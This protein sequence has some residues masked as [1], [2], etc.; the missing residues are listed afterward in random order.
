MTVTATLEVHDGA[1]WVEIPVRSWEMQETGRNP[2][3][4]LRC[5]IVSAALNST[6]LSLL[7]LYRRM[8]WTHEVDGVDFSFTGRIMADPR[9]LVGPELDIITLTCYDETHDAARYRFVD[10]WPKLDVDTWSEIIEDAWTRYGPKG[11]T[12]TGVESNTA[13]PDYISNPLNTLFDFM[14]DI[15]QRT[16]WRWKVVDGD[17]KFWDPT[18]NVGAQTITATD[19]RPG[20]MVDEG[21]PEVANIVFIP[22]E[23]RVQD[24]EDSQTT[25]TGRKQYFLQYSPLEIP[26]VTV[27]GTPVSE[28]DMAADGTPDADTADLVYNLENRFLRFAVAPTGGVD[29]VATYDAVLPVTVER[30]HPVS[31]GLYGEIQHTIRRSPRPSR[32][33]AAEIAD[34]YLAVHAL[35]VTAMKAEMLDKT[36]QCGWYYQ[37]TLEHIDQLMPCVAVSRAG[38]SDGR[39]VV[40]ASWQQAPVSD[41]EMIFDLFRRLER[42][43]A[44][45]TSKDER[46]ERDLNIEDTWHWSD[47]VEFAWS[48]CEFIS[49][50]AELKHGAMYICEQATGRQLYP[51]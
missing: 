37:V 38:H 33:E 48:D 34:A 9:K 24:F 40:T 49:D 42:L 16:G 14:E 6:Q 41:A 25:V 19:I 22:A 20:S 4:E 29:L 46:I 26:T 13:E 31:I 32:E 51:C 12:F 3:T 47:L 5:E 23:F 50:T 8:K 18:A 35:P 15:A 1:D 2:V 44:R 7:T 28:E 27:D 30:Q 21:M 36:V 45:E 43:E 17:L 10:S 39:Y 11:I